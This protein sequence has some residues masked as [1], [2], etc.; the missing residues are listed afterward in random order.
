M[1]VRVHHTV[2]DPGVVY[3]ELVVV[4]VLLRRIRKRVAGWLKRR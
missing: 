2:V 3:S 4:L 1:R